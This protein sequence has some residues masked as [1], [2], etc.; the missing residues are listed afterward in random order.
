MVS[1]LY[2]IAAPKLF[3]HFFFKS[4]SSPS[5]IFSIVNPVHPYNKVNTGVK[6]AKNK[7]GMKVSG[8]TPSAAAANMAL[9]F[10]AYLTVMNRSEERRVG[11]E[12]RS[13]WWREWWRK[14]SKIDCVVDSC[15][16]EG[17]RK[18]AAR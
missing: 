15:S 2:K 11:K 7:N 14:N 13:R 12:C 8:A 6:N 4:S 17:H 9:P 18:S 16:I 1:L 5:S 10:P 3:L